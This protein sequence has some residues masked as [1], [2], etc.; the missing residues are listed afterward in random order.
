MNKSVV[1]R[2]HQKISD[3]KK[4]FIL[5]CIEASSGTG[6]VCSTYVKLQKPGRQCSISK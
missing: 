6:H 4:G 3:G 1:F 2:I 5:L